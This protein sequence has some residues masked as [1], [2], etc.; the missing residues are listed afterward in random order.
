M[1]GLYTR[2]FHR[3]SPFWHLLQRCHGALLQCYD[4]DRPVLHG[5]G[6]GGK[7]VHVR[8]CRN[9]RRRILDTIRYTVV[10]EREGQLQAGGGRAMLFQRA[11][12]QLPLG[13]RREA[14]WP[15]TDTCTLCSAE[16]CC[17]CIRPVEN[18]GAKAA[19]HRTAQHS[20]AQH[21]TAQHSTAQHSALRLIVWEGPRTAGSM[22]LTMAMTMT[23]ATN[24]AHVLRFGKAV[25][26]M[27]GCLHFSYVS[28]YRSMQ[29]S[30]PVVREPNGVDAGLRYIR[31]RSTPGSI[32]LARDLPSV[33]F[34]F[35]HTRIL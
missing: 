17:G 9:G 12:S 14:G 27:V 22:T 4:T 23:T 7:S 34:L 6:D 3:R 21:S 13:S 31:G 1:G 26:G 20:T 25:L 16:C 33:L 10:D 24:S 5:G 2:H 28:I 8:H 35:N 11:T 18:C 32:R 29:I 19:P 30:T 15:Y